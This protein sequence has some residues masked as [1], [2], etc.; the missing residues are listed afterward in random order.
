MNKLTSAFSL[1]VVYVGITST[2]WL[3]FSIAEEKND[4]K[5]VK[6]TLDRSELSDSK[7]EPLTLTMDEHEGCEIC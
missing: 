4:S 3:N 1:V 7:K 6:L 5:E 2:S